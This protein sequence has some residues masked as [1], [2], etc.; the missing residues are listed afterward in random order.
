[1]AEGIL[2][3]FH[4]DEFQVYSAGVYPSEVNPLAIEVMDEIGIDI[5]KHTSKSI[6][7]FL[8]RKIDVVITVCD[9]AKEACP[10]FPGASKLLHW[11][12]PDPSAAKGSGQRVLQAFRDTRDSIKERIL[13][14][15][16]KRELS[17]E[18]APDYGKFSVSKSG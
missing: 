8:G 12:F 13:E 9:E 11:S 1:M 10:H 6:R 15:V 7:E 5:S 3:H 16:R 18:G 2:R 14:A 17:G 4:G